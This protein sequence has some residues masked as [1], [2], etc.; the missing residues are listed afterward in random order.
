MKDEDTKEDC[1][2]QETPTWMTDEEMR[3][4]F[5]SDKDTISKVSTHQTSTVDHYR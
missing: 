5:D 2:Y 3:K 4:F 1:Y